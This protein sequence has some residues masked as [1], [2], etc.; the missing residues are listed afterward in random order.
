[1][2]VTAWVYG[3]AR[4]LVDRK[5]RPALAEHEGGIQ[6]D[7]AHHAIATWRPPGHHK[8]PVVTAGGKPGH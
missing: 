1:M 3:P 6:R 5:L 2:D 8:Q 7:Q 4:P